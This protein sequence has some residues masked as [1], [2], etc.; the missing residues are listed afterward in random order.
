MLYSLIAG[1]LIMALTFVLRYSHL[2]PQ[3]PLF[4]SYP[5]GED[6]VVDLWMIIILPIVMNVFFFTNQLLLRRFFRGNEVIK[7]L[8]NVT[9]IFLVVA[10]TLIFVK[11]I[12]M[13]S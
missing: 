11:I 5:S 8:I 6:Q 7:K 12:T 2:P 1:N 13:V 10:I 9:N 3:I 4:Y